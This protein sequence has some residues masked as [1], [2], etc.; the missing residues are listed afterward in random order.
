MKFT[1]IKIWNP[2]KLTDESYE[3]SGVL[4][5]ISSPFRSLASLLNRTP[6]N[7]S[8]KTPK[9][10][11]GRELNLDNLELRPLRPLQP[12]SIVD[13]LYNAPPSRASVCLQLD[14][15]FFISTTQC[16][17]GNVISFV[18]LAPP[19]E[20]WNRPLFPSLFPSHLLAK[21]PANLRLWKGG[22]GR[23]T[24]KPPVTG[25]SLCISNPRILYF[26]CN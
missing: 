8:P 22:G 5:A 18:Y 7:N 13:S 9:T 1:N 2:V 25:C 3:R 17:S 24:E 26:C 4:S 10:T 23:Q 14:H 19:L 15:G 21:S 20:N 11:V 16:L 6:T 12:D